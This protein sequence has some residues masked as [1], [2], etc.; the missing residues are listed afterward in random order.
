MD[1][2]NNDNVDAYLLDCLSLQYLVIVLGVVLGKIQ[3]CVVPSH[4]KHDNT[5]F[6]TMPSQGVLLLLDTS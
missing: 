4:S 6:Y 2:I 3:D 1:D 5:L